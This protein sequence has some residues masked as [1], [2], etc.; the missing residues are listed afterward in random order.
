MIA[1]TNVRTVHGT[2]CIVAIFPRYV[3]LTTI[4]L[5]QEF[6]G[7]S[8]E[9]VEIQLWNWLHRRARLKS[10]GPRNVED[11]VRELLRTIR[12]PEKP[13][14]V[15][16][17]HYR[18]S[19]CRRESYRIERDITISHWDRVYIHFGTYH[20]EHMAKRASVRLCEIINEEIES[21]NQQLCPRKPSEPK[22]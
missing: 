19:R 4:R 18:R 22:Q 1:E 6:R 2:E 16:A 3:V 13:I 9:E 12:L 7:R 8:V 15:S 20:S 10:D 14:R 11:D 5:R 21:R 17:G